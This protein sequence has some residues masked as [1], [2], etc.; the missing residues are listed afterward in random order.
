MMSVNPTAGSVSQPLVPAGPDDM[1]S[2]LIRAIA[3]MR[4]LDE[5][6]VL[7]EVAAGGGDVVI[8][9]KDAVVVIPLAEK[10][11]GGDRLVEVSDLKRRELTSLRNLGDLMWRRWSERHG[12]SNA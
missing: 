11:F 4:V 7:G 10:E 5:E 1:L 8:E 3:Y 6:E 12:G 9:S 2:A